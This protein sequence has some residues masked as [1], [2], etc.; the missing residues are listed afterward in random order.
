M[1]H[2][3]IK[4]IRLSAIVLACL[5]ATGCASISPLA[6]SVDTLQNINNQ[7]RAKNAEAV[8]PITAP[9]SME[10]ALARALK[11]NLERRSRLMEEALAMG[12]LSVTK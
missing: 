11:Y 5:V 4:P 2:T 9:L 3:N 10:A 8:E 6:A 12:Q 1:Q 7:D